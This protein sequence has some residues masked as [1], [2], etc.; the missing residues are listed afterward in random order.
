MNEGK[1]EGFPVRFTRVVISPRPRYARD[2]AR[3]SDLWLSRFS[4]FFL[5]SFPF[6]KSSARDF[7]QTPITIGQ[8]ALE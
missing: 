7:E 4:L 1:D 6:F 5:F 3:A 2:D 8:S